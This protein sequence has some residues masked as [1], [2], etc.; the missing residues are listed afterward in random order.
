MGSNSK[1]KYANACNKDRISALPDEIICDILSTLSTKE[2]VRTSI[3]SPR[4]RNV[5]AHVPTLDLCDKHYQREFNPVGFS[6]FVDRALCI[7]SPFNN[8]EFRLSSAFAEF[9]DRA[10]S[11]RGSSKIHRLRLCCSGVKNYPLIDAWIRT[12]IRLNVV[13]LELVLYSFG[14][15]FELARNL[16]TCKTLVVLKLLLESNIT[17]TPT[18]DCF[19]SL[20]FFHAKVYDPD[21]DSMEKLFSSCPALEELIIGGDIVASKV[22]NFNIEAPELN[23][24]KIFLAEDDFWEGSESNIFFNVNA[25]NLEKFDLEADFVANYILNANSLSEAKI[26]LEYVH[27]SGYIDYELGCVDR[28]ERLFAGL[29]NV[30]YLS[31]SAPLFGDPECHTEDGFHLP[32]LNR[33]NHLELLLFTCCNWKSLIDLLKIS[34][35]LEHLDVYNNKE[36]T[37]ENYRD[38]LV[39]EWVPPEFVPICLLSHLKT[40]CL[41]GIQGRPDE[42]EVT[43]YL[44]KHG[45]VLNKV[46]IY[47]CDFRV[48]DK[49]KL[50]QEISMF[51]K[52]STTCQ[53]EF[54]EK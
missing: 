32:E 19:P 35:H 2:A 12:A 22:L 23:R 52:G 25:P 39:C 41:R 44:L 16:F 18:S 46:T 34:P 11:I 1:L 33:L 43:K 15:P 13:E 54:L 20:K 37:L 31:L 14:R 29:L 50:C 47:T 27:T 36:C 38:L 45:E 5:W 49:V 48:E 8:H 6:E 26:D 17:F 10:L 21:A 28:L 7:H 40:I 53:I 3:I 4:W 24:L 30:K 51:S 9:V 42:T